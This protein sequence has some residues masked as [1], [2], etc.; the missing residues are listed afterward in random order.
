MTASKP[1]PIC[2]RCAGKGYLWS[3]IPNGEW[4]VQGMCPECGGTG[5]PRDPKQEKEG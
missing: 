2:D 5:K 4:K 3:L 1:A